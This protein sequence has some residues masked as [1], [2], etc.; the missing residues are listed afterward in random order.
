MR[1]DDTHKTRNGPKK[2]IWY[3]ARIL[4]DVDLSERI[5]EEV[6]VEREGYAFY[7]L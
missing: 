6:M 1:K 2:I 3:Y 7:V 5:F 4:V